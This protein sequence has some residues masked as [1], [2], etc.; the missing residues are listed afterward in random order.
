MLEAITVGQTC[1]PA[2]I[3][4]TFGFH[5]TSAPEMAK[6][7][8]LELAGAEPGKAHNPALGILGQVRYSIRATVSS[9]GFGNHDNRARIRIA[10]RT[11]MALAAKKNHSRRRSGSTDNSGAERMPNDPALRESLAYRTPKQHRSGNDANT[12]SLSSSTRQAKRRNSTGRR[13][14]R[15]SGSRTSG[16]SRDAQPGHLIYVS[17]P[18]RVRFHSSEQVL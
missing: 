8:K 17:W 13:S 12:H 6:R 14:V 3:R 2:N 9:D 5:A 10:S 18:A 16:R 15:R 7:E 4:I 1:S 11:F